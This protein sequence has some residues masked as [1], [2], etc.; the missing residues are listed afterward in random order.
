MADENYSAIKSRREAVLQRAREVFGGAL[1]AQEWA[2][3]PH[4]MLD[5]L[6]PL[7]AC[8]T[9]IGESRAHRI[10]ASIAH[11]MPA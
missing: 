2:M 7:D 5:G 3:T 10:L 4:G 11:E 8:E 9:L 6:T 1:E